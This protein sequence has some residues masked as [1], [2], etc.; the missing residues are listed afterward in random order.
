MS[1]DRKVPDFKVKL[2][3]Q[4]LP[5]S[6]FAQLQLVEVEQSIGLIDMAT[7]TL[8]NPKGTVAD[9]SCFKH[10]ADLVIEAGYVGK[11]TRVFQGDVVSIEPHFPTS[12]TPS[13]VVRAYDRL[14]RY[15][16]G[17]KQRTFLSSKVSDVISQLA[18]EEG[19]SAQVEATQGTRDYLF[20]NNQSNVELILE[21]ARRE[22][23]EVEVN[24]AGKLFVGKPRLKQAK[25][26]VLTWG[27]DLKGFYVRSSASNVKSEVSV[28]YWDMKQKTSITEVNQQLDA[29]LEPQ[30]EAVATAKKAFGEAKAQV[31]VRPC[32]DAGEAKALATAIFS[33]SALDAVQA[34]ATAMGEASLIPGKI[35]ELL[36]LGKMW[37][38]LY[39]VSGATHLFT[40]EAGYSS[41]LLL[42]R[43]G[44]G[45][46]VENRIIDPP[47][48]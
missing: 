25:A 29:K 41:E 6:L 48:A 19:L 46:P 43:N 40:A 15:H 33:Q 39:Y 3:G 45:Y 8:G 37:S 12:G 21:L 17:R 42:R 36:G 24:E 11:V 26:G 30:D 10:G 47:S 38:G 20:Q 7:L 18:G 35:V 27:V 22:G 32:T 14:H 34:R 4:A 16:R 23:F 1:E 2:D 28:R 31:S 44:T 9:L 13:V 5:P